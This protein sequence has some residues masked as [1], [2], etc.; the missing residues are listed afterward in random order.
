MTT[1]AEM[2]ARGV[3]YTPTVELSGD[4]PEEYM[5]PA[6]PVRAYR[7]R[8]LDCWRMQAGPPRMQAAGRLFHRYGQAALYALRL[9][10]EAGRH[11]EADRRVIAEFLVAAGVTGQMELFGGDDD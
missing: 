9:E 8:I 2:T 3:G 4:G 5:F 10:A 11:T 1:Y 6:D 7:V